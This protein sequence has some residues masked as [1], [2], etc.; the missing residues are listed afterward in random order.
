MK[1]SWFTWLTVLGMIVSAPSMARAE[2]PCLTQV[3]T[4]KDMLRAAARAQKAPRSLAAARGQDVQAPRAGQ[5]VQAP[6]AG[7]EV[8]A[9]RAGQEVQAPRAGQEVQA[10]RSATNTKARTSTLANARRLVREA[11]AACKT[12]DDARAAANAKAA[13]ELLRYLQP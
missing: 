9:P 1:A 12:K 2:T 3:Q 10:P 11:D 6:R 13:I 8:Q 7:Q 4:A 5:E